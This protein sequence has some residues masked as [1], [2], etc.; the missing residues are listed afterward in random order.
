M[1]GE[2]FFLILEGNIRVQRRLLNST[3]NSELI[4]KVVN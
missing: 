1:V 4:V 3:V 2:N